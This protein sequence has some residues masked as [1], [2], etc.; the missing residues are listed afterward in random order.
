M[1]RI[2]SWNVGQR[3]MPWHS[4][5][6]S[7]VDVA[8]LQEAQPPP[9]ELSSV[10]EIDQPR[11]WYTAGIGANKSWRAAVARFSE[12]VAMRPHKTN[13]VEAAQPDELAVSR[14]GTLA[15]A[16][17][18]VG[19]T[20][21]IIT[22]L[23]MYSKWEK[24]V[25]STGSSLIYADASAHRLI[26]DISALIGRQRD[27]KIIAAG[28]LNILHGY[29]ED[30]SPYWAARYHTVFARMKAI[31]LPFVGPQAPDGSEQA[32]PWPDELPKDSKNVPTFRTRIQQPETATR[33]LDFVFASE[34]LR[35]RLRVRALNSSDEWGP[36]DHC[37]ILIELADQ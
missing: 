14:T 13:S 37:R 5:V 15:A 24:P 7:G 21:E 25:E 20:G 11:P 22:V 36:S 30:G 3:V 12:R 10:I 31:G 34:P 17:I 29:G 23:S 2:V 19:S 35:D 28:D 1:L 32:S 18:V 9:A 26:S 6:D 16:D 4:L 27:H 33:Q 8:L